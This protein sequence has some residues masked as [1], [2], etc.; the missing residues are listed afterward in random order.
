MVCPDPAVANAVAACVNWRNCGFACKPSYGDCNGDPADGCETALAS[1]PLNCGGCGV[2]CRHGCVQGVCA[3]RW[4]GESHVSGLTDGPWPAMPAHII[5]TSW[6]GGTLDVREGPRDGGDAITLASV[7]A[8]AGAPAAVAQV[9]GSFYSP[10]THTYADA[11]YFTTGE[12]GQG[13]VYRL[14]LDTGAVPQQIAS[15][16]D[17]PGSLLLTDAGVYWTNYLGGQ[18]MRAPVDGGMPE[19]VASGMLHPRQLTTDDARVFWINEGTDGGDGSVMAAPVA[20][21][22]ATRVSDDASGGAPT[23]ISLLWHNV[24]SGPQQTLLKWPVWADR[25]SREIWTLNNATPQ[26]LLHPSDAPTDWDPRQMFPAG[27]SFSVFD[28]AHPGVYGPDQAFIP[29]DGSHQPPFNLARIEDEPTGAIALSTP[30]HTF[31]TDGSTIGNS[32]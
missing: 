23:A 20:G 13:A 16:Q 24:L 30:W 31:W 27:E 29:G 18:V 9:G 7:P 26:A 32:P 25:R 6:D 14:A 17:G 8:A 1:D 2:H 3:L 22:P 10:V 4:E 12:A 5:W 11:I 21:G 15:G 28:A 19:V